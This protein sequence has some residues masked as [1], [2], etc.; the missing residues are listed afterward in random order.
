[1]DVIDLHPRRACSINRLD[2]GSKIVGKRCTSRSSPSG[3]LHP[4]IK[5]VF[6]RVDRI[7]S[8]TLFVANRGLRPPTFCI[9]CTDFGGALFVRAIPGSCPLTS[10]FLV[11]ELSAIF[12]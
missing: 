1:M 7:F 11:L 9:K 4:A 3:S 6:L 10:S 2:L 12:R 8:H 5:P